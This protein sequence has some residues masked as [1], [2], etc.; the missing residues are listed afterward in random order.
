MKK[1]AFFSLCLFIFATNLFVILTAC[2]K[3]IAP[4][5]GP[6]VDTTGGDKTPVDPPIANTMGFFL[7]DWAPRNFSVPAFEEAVKPSAAANVF[8]TIDAADVITKI[9]RTVFGQNAN[10]WMT[11]IQTEPV[12]LNHLKKLL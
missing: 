7:N 3:P 10:I 12:L 6:G 8:V 11:Q 1:Q 4:G 9:P 5:P 2:S